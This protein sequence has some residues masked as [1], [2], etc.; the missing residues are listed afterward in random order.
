MGEEDGIL[1]RNTYAYSYDFCT[2]E[3]W[4]SYYSKSY[5]T[6]WP[7]AGAAALSLGF[8]WSSDSQTEFVAF[9]NNGTG[10]YRIALD[11]NEDYSSVTVAVKSMSGFNLEPWGG[12]AD[13]TLLAEYRVKTDGSQI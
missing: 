13:G 7:E 3:L 2:S 9:D 12:T 10:E 6:F 8:D 4:P 11:F 1:W 5:L